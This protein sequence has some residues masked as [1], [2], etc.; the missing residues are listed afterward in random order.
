VRGK[1][2][3]V[4]VNDP[5]WQT[6]TLAGPFRGRAMTYYGRWTYKYE[7]AAGQGAAAVFIV[8]QTEPAAYGWNVVQSSWTGAQYNTDDPGNHMD[9]SEVIGWLTQDAAR[10]LF[11]ASGQ[12][13]DALTRAAGERGFRPVP[14]GTRATISLDN[15]IR[16]SVS[17]N[18]IGI[19]PGT[20]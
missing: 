14:L 20:E 12:D 2:V 17:H 9:Q 8:P 1:T 3:I 5:D 4:L 6:Q 7:E 18:V 10:R 13:L 15:R 16:R 11:A 19:L